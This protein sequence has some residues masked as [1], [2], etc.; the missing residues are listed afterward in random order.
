MAIDDFKLYWN[1]NELSGVNVADQTGVNTGTSEGGLSFTE[2]RIHSGR[3]F[4]GIDDAIRNTALTPSFTADVTVSIWVNF[5]SSA[6][7][8]RIL[9]FCQAGGSGFPGINIK[10]GEVGNAG[11]LALDN[12]G[13]PTTELTTATTINDGLWHHAAVTRSGTTY[14]FYV[15]RQVVGTSGGTLLTYTQ[16]LVGVSSELGNLRWFLGYL[17]ELR[18]YDRALSEPELDQLR[19]FGIR[20]ILGRRIVAGSGI[21]TNDMAL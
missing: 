19:D 4:D 21:S 10:M 12:S 5:T 13:G 1:M 7:N 2:G 8:L 17:D 11:K 15:D 3:F 9:D 18:A 20:R 16:M 14:T 6:N